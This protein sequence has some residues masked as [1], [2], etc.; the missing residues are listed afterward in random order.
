MESIKI[1]IPPNLNFVPGVRTLVART[2]FIYGFSER[3]SYQIETIV[4]EICNNAIEHGSKSKEDVVTIECCFDQ[5]KVE[6]SVT[7]NGNKKFEPDKIIA[8]NLKLMEEEQ[9]DINIFERRGRGLVIV[10]KLSDNLDINV[11]EK[12]TEVRVIKK[13]GLTSL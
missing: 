9:K 8:S 2:S 7:D 13:R 5:E 3:E 1:N 10:K 11:G 4:D 6:V 12:G